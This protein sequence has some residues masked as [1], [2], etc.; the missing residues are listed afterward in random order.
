MVDAA[1]N[2][3]LA[4]AAAMVR[5]A[6]E[7]AA[8]PAPLPPEDGSVALRAA[9]IDAIRTGDADGAE[10]AMRMLVELAWEAI[11]RGEAPR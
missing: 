1:H 3:L 2:S 7:A 8:N 9:V 10:K 6:L 4:H 11:A 5:V